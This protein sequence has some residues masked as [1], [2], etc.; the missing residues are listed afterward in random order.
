MCKHSFRT[1]LEML[2]PRFRFCHDFG[3]FQIYIL[4][5]WK[6]EVMENGGFKEEN[7]KDKCRSKGAYASQVIWRVGPQKN[8]L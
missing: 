1:I 4:T 3:L 7:E 2:Y 8:F 5:L 6:L